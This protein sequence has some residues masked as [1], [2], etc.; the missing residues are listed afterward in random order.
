MDSSLQTRYNRIKRELFDMKYSFLNDMQRD[1][2]FTVN[3]PLLVL[4]GAGSG[5]TKVLTERIGFIIR[6]GNAYYDDSVPDN[7]NED[8]IKELELLKK[9]GKVTSEDLDRFAVGGCNPWEILAITFTNKAAG[10]MKSRLEAL[11]GEKARDIWC[12]TFHSMCLR[13]LRSNYEKAGLVPGFSIF[14]EDDSKKLISAIIKEYDIDEKAFPVRNLK[15]DISRAKD[16]L[17]TTKEF[18]DEVG[19]DYKL[20][21][22]SLV[23]SAY[24]KKLEENGAVDFDDII[25]KTVLL[26]NDNKEILDYYRR[27]FKYIAIDEFQDTNFAQ[28][29]FANC[30][31]GKYRNIMVVGDDDQSIYKFRGAT[32][33]NIL[34]FDDKYEDVK[35]IKLEQNYRSTQ[36]I[37]SAANSVIKHNYGR[38]GK[39]LWTSGQDGEKV[40]I[41]QVDNQNDEAKFIVSKILELMLKERRRYSDFAILYRTNA[42]SNVLESVFVKSGMPYRILGSHKFYDRKEVKDILAYLY[43]ISNPDDS[44]HLLRI[45]NEPKRK[46]GDST[47]SSVTMISEYEEKSVFN[48]MT[49][50]DDYISIAKS[51]S[52]F[53]PFINLINELR[54]DATKLSVSELVRNTIEKSGYGLMLSSSNDEESKERLQNVDE[55]VSAAMEYED[56]NDEPTL[57]GF[58]ESVSLVSDIDDYDADAD[59]VVMMTIHSAKGLEFPVVF[60]PGM[61]EDLFPSYKNALDPAELEEERRLA[62]VAI[63]RAKERLFMLYARGRTLY[64]RTTFGNPSRF[65]DEIE[66]DNKTVEYDKTRNVIRNEVYDTRIQRHPPRISGELLSKSNPTSKVGMTKPSELVAFEVG[67]RVKHVLFGLGTIMSVKEMGADVLYEIAFDN[68]GTKKLMATFAKLQKGE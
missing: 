21:K 17:I 12:G 33:E 16:K 23:Y 47:M 50:A 41:R 46:L 59:A 9:S 58:L 13:I 18:D 37:L 3:G 25:M 4:A 15:N 43:V 44:Y 14:D 64:G 2:V 55:L 11:V 30:L 38:R 54:D 19:N 45:V 57:Q 24:Q 53:Q 60:V 32:I 61:E 68:F 27:K 6:Y 63:T 67:S 62:Y 8:T 5:K 56:E 1:A 48:V 35:I 29:E 20:Q 26:L 7:V 51:K 42:Q 40:F 22:T 66:E 28:F 49:H 31:A 39:N 34:H 65:L 52:K 36:N 10:E